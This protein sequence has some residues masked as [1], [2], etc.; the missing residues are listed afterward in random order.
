MKTKTLLPVFVASFILHPSAFAQGALTPPGAPA[1]TMKSLAQIEPRTPISSLPFTI[2]APGAYYVTTN[3]T[4]V[5]GS[6]GITITSGNV[7]LDL[8]GFLL[9][10]VPGSFNGI[11]TLGT[12]TNVT[13]GNGS[14]SGWSFS[15]VN[16]SA[17]TPRN[18]VI[19]HLNISACGVSGISAVNAVICDCTVVGSGGDGIDAVYC[20]VRDCTVDGC[21][22]SYGIYLAPGT[23]T[24]CLV[25][26]EF[27]TGIYC[28]APGCV[29]SDNV[30]RNNNTGN[31]ASSAG[32]L[33]NDADNRIEN[34]QVV[35]NGVMGA[36]IGGGAG[37]TGNLII[38]N[39][40]AGGGAN[41]YVITG[42]QVVGPISTTT[43]TITSTSPWANFSY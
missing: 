37:Y 42:T 38:K 34:N 22:G 17:G 26:R 35:G 4:G 12:C 20:T 19:H 23:A 40:V 9:A 43:G 39:F 1:P 25:I 15:G 3:L 29:V 16:I 18:V 7:T 32:I 5:S 2:S 33:L 28:N 14:L 30:V 41:N 11:S 31:F 6:S 13:V 36:G 21:A 8:G 24:R 10:N 27:A